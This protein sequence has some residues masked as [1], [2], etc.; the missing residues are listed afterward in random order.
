MRFILEDLWLAMIRAIEQHSTE[1]EQA[2]LLRNKVP[3][4][5]WFFTHFGRMENRL[6][7]KQAPPKFIRL[8]HV[9][10]RY[11]HG[12]DTK[13]LRLERLTL[14][15]WGNSAERPRLRSVCGR[16][17]FNE[18][19]TDWASTATTSAFGVVDSGSGGGRCS[20]AAASGPQATVPRRR[21][22]ER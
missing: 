21:D 12:S 16:R 17:M 22:V 1:N 15:W 13:L 20:R 14:H 18:V 5:Q 6:G 19:M 9:F 10:E 4:W 8:A 7:S 11:G 2:K 3:F